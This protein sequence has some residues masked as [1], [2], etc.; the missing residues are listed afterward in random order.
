MKNIEFDQD[1]DNKIAKCDEVI[2]RFQLLDTPKFD[3]HDS[4]YED[5]T[6]AILL[7]F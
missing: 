1:V 3:H 2:W 5:R 6:K 7:K 4:F